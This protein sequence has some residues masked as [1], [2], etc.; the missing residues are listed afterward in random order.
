[1][2]D[3]LNRPLPVGPR[4]VLFGVHQFAIHPLFVAAAW[5]RLYGFP[6]DPR[7]WVAFY[8][9]DLGYLF[10]WCRNMDGPEGELHVLFGAAIMGRLFGK[11]WGDFCR[12]HS[13]YYAARDGHAYSRLCVADKLSI[14]ITPA[15]LYL[16]AARATGELTEYLALARSR[17][18]AHEMLNQAELAGLT[19]QDPCAWYSSLCAYMLRWVEQHRDGAEDTWTPQR[20]RSEAAGANAPDP[21]RNVKGGLL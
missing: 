4:S 5:K 9:H 17:A 20:Y 11:E 10:R 21:L 13:R 8:V 6:W 15:W 16:P 1:M 7:L 12:Y 2:K 19:S 18:T 3:L 14:A